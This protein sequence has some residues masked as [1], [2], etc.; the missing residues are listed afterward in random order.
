MPLSFPVAEAEVNITAAQAVLKLVQDL[1][2]AA[3]L[4][5]HAVAARCWDEKT[6]SARLGTAAF[7]EALGI[8]TP[9]GAQQAVRRAVDH[10]WLV[11]ENRTQEGTLYRLGGQLRLGGGQPP[12]AGAPS[13]VSKGP[14]TVGPLRHKDIKDKGAAAQN[15]QRPQRRPVDKTD[16]RRMTEADLLAGL[17]SMSQEQAFEAGRRRLRQLSAEHRALKGR[18]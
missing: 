5:V 8:K 6:Y 12:L 7:M 2:P 4:A 11:V 16:P 17:A 14:T 10:G 13:T 9:Q 18:T 15:G 3:K 1:D